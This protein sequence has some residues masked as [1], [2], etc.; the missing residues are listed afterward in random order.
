MLKR[1]VIHTW[2]VHIVSQVPTLSDCCIQDMEEDSPLLWWSVGGLKY[3]TLQINSFISMC[4]VQ[5]RARDYFSVCSWLQK[6]Y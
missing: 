1:S 5:Q 2:P 4:R 6:V 3:V